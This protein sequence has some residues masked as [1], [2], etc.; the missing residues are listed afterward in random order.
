MEP[1]R[2]TGPSSCKQLLALD[3]GGVRGAISV[4]FIERIEAI[5]KERSGRGEAFRLSDHFDLI[6]GTSTGAIIGTAL[7]LGLRAS[8]VKDLY[9]RLAPRVFR[10]SRWRLSLVQTIFDATVLQ[11]EIAGIVGDRR[12]D[13]PDLRTNLAI[14]MKRMD[15]GGTWIITNCPHAKFWDDPADGSYIGNKHFRLASLVRAST[16]APYFFAPEEVSVMDGRPPGVFLDGGLTPH[17][18]PSLALLQVATI[19]AYGFHWPVGADKLHIVSVGTGSHRLCIGRTAARRMLAAQFAARSLVTMIGDN[20]TQVLTMMQI[21]GRSH[22]PW[23]INTEVGDLDGF[24]LPSDPLFT[25][26]RYD[27]L[28]SRAWLRAELNLKL[29]DREVERLYAMDNAESIPLLYE[30]GQAAAAKLV[31]PEHLLPA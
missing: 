20:S 18:N 11:R 8:E 1:A 10:R 14:V 23:T 15:T 25:F 30:M 29:S 17:N 5:C 16:A 3:G 22:T 12:L 7:A 19:P 13:T 28:L 9:L 24:L 6:G 31:Q 26:Q 4:A 21:L 27:L 2:Q